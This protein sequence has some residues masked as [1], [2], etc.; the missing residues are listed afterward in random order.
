MRIRHLL[1]LGISVCLYSQANATKYVYISS[2]EELAAFRDAVNSDGKV[3]AVDDVTQD[4]SEV[5]AKTA[6]VILTKDIDLSNISNWTPIGISKSFYFGG[7]FDGGN[8]TVMNLNID[9]PDMIYQGYGLFGYISAAEIK[10]L[11]VKGAI[12]S[13]QQT[14]GIAGFAANYSTISNCQNYC[15]ISSGSNVGGIIGKRSNVTISN[16]INW[17]D[18][19]GTDDCIGGIA[20]SYKGELSNCANYGTV[21]GKS[22]VSGL[23]GNMVETD[24]NFTSCFNYGDVNCTG[25]GTSGVLCGRDIAVSA[26]NCFYNS[27]ATYPSGVATNGATAKSASDFASG[28]VA[29]LLN[30]GNDV[31]K[32]TLGADPYPVFEGGT[33]YQHTLASGIIYSNS[34]ELDIVYH[35]DGT[36][37]EL[38]WQTDSSFAPADNSFL[39]TTN[40]GINGHNVVLKNGDGTYTC[41]KFCLTDGEA[42]H[43]DIDFTVDTL[44]YNRAA[45]ASAIVTMVLPA[46]IPTDY[47]KG[48]LYVFSDFDGTNVHFSS[49]EQETTE[50]NKPYAIKPED[51]QTTILENGARNVTIKAA[52]EITE[53][54]HNN[55]TCFGEYETAS[56][57]SD[58][59]FSY[60]VFSGGKLKKYKKI[61]LSPFRAGFR[62]GLD[63]NNTSGT[64]GLKL[65][66]ELSGVIVIENGEEELGK[67]N[68]FDIEG[69][70]VRANAEPTTCF[71][72]LAKGIYIVNGR[73]FNINPN[74]AGI[75]APNSLKKAAAGTGF[76]E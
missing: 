23:I 62:L 1:L 53:I 17:G 55:L 36:Q 38:V 54:A 65:D 47:L 8:H 64:L 69:R 4:G 15:T 59:H 57:N 43:S 34:A 46:D 27:D 50:A 13:V 2:A 74:T 28:A 29:Y 9:A 63:F 67:V 21:T 18:I 66:N 60:I 33:V 45:T 5:D 48:N 30:N 32:Q 68:V 3:I 58:D 24:A 37:D 61:N 31:W 52:D 7:I 14:G 72:G 75:S 39:V 25:T 22:D 73:K 12:E 44:T 26:T 56:Y 71:S 11:S 6:N 42:F 76:A 70:L 10:N 40:A 51:A 41:K 49:Y 35:A 20:G 16:C 19:T